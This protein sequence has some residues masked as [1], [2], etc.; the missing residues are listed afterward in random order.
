ML[1]LQF[2]SLEGSLTDCFICRIR[3]KV[4]ARIPSPMKNTTEE[5]FLAGGCLWGVQEFFRYVPGIISTEAGRANG[6]S[7]KIDGPYDGYTECVMT[8]FDSEKISVS[9]LMEYLFEIIDPYSIDRQGP[10]IGKK[11]RTGVYSKVQRH[12]DLARSFIQSRSDH[13]R[14]SLEVLPLTNYVRSAAEHQNRLMRHPEEKCHIPKEL[15][16]KYRR[17]GCLK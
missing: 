10:H 5:I 14:I 7:D 3:Q 1:H 12:L 4:I 9:Q 17:S 8:I 16:R 2:N 15:L 11:Y 13:S 6:A